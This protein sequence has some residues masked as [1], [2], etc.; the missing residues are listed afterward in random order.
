MPCVEAFSGLEI[1]QVF[2]VSPHHY[3][4]LSAFK[5]V[6]PLLECQ[7]DGEEF[8]VAHVIVSLRLR[9]PSREKSTVVKL[10]IFLQGKDRSYSRVG[11]VHLHDERPV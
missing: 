5:L 4:L 2:V 9:Q 8:P 11:C 10:A 6:S 1:S 3:G 7:L